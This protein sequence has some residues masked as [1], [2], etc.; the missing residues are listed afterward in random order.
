[1]LK[2]YRNGSDVLVPVTVQQMPTNFGSSSVGQNN[3]S[4]PDAGQ[5][6]SGPDG[7]DEGQN[8]V[9]FGF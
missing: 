9:P 7:G 5:G 3:Q 6:Q 1:M 4:G 8:Q 2:V